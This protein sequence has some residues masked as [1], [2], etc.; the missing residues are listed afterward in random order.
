MAACTIASVCMCTRD[1]VSAMTAKCWTS[2]RIKF[3]ADSLSARF[4]VT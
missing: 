3:N 2:N 1:T 4:K